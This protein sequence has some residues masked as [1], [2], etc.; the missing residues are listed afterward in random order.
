MTK[1]DYEL[2]AGV[3]NR[4]W[5]RHADPLGRESLK[6]LCNDLADALRQDNSHFDRWRFLAACGMVQ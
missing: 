6:L 5:D 4:Q 2:I 1:K 3:I